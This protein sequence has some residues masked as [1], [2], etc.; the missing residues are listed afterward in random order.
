M[1]KKINQDDYLISETGNWNVASDYS[2]LK[3][4]KPLYLADEYETVAIF[5]TSSLIE[6]MQ[7]N[8]NI[9]VLKISSFKRLVSTLTLLINNTYFA[10]KQKDGQKKLEDFKKELKKIELI[11]PT[12]YK[13]KIDSRKKTKEIILIEDRYNKILSRVSEIKSL[14]NEPLNKSHLIFTDKEEFDPKAFKKKI[15]EDAISRG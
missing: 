11:I 14:I 5:G 9:D 6:E 10:I 15:F 13:T 2:R 1:P 12:L 7:I 4:M 3:I 8:I